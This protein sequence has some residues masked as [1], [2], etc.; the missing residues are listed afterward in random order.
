MKTSSRVYLIPLLATFTVVAGIYWIAAQ[1]VWKH[2]V[3]ELQ[4]L[5]T[6]Q[7]DRFVSHLSGQLARFVFLPELLAKNQFLVEVLHDPE[8][9]ARI[10]LANRYLEEINA[11]TGA[12]DTY[13]M[14]TDGTTLAASNWQS[15]RPFVGANFSFRPYFQTA[16]QGRLGRYFALGTTSKQRGY[17]FAFPITHAASIKGVIVL[18]MDL[19]DIEERWSGKAEQYLVTDPHGV[20]FITTLP[21]LL[22]RTTSKLSD[23]QRQEIKNSRRYPGA[24]LIHLPLL[25]R[26]GLSDGAAIVRIGTDEVE[27]GGAQLSLSRDMPDAGWSVRVLTPMQGITRDVLTTLAVLTLSLMLFGSLLVSWLQRGRRRRERERFAAEAKRQLEQ[28]VAARTSDLTREVDERR[29]TEQELRN[30]RDELVQTAKLAVLGQLSASISHELNNPLAAIR[31]YADNARV[32]LAREQHEQVEQNLGRISGLTERMAK[33]ST[34]LK[35]F[36]RKSPGQLERVSVKAAIH[37]A[38]DIVNPQRDRKGVDIRIEMPPQDL[39]VKV[40]AIQLEQVLVNLLSNAMQAVESAESKIVT[41]SGEAVADLALIHV[42]DSGP[43]IA[44]DHLTQVFDP[45]FTTKKSGLGLGLSISY[46]IIDS[47]HGHLNAQ[48]LETGGARFTVALPLTGAAE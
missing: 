23:A 6:Q 3:A 30:T 33:I 14:D 31:S 15:D 28:Q 42:D 7:L 11:I 46:R 35:V 20:I 36:A 40:D 37:A 38:V 48:N 12:A 5:S 2:G 22:Y 8:N 1:I 4:A 43:G 13:L 19:S 41:L 39:F 32:L 25:Y 24:S 9:P 10:D 44:D 45:F 34:Q 29:R 17:Y 16:I 27:L 18:K 21:T 26:R 47:M